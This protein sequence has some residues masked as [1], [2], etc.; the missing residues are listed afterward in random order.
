M[1][2]NDNFQ[3]FVTNIADALRIRYKTSGLFSPNEFYS[4]ILELSGVTD[5][6]SYEI[7]SVQQFTTH[8]GNS[9]RKARRLGN[10]LINPQDYYDHILKVSGDTVGDVCIYDMLNNNRLIVSVNDLS[11]YSDKSIYTP[12]GVVVIPSTHDIY[13]DGSCGIMALKEM[14]ATNTTEGITGHEYIHWG[15]PYTNTNLPYYQYVIGNDSSLNESGYLPNENGTYDSTPKS[16]SPYNSDGSRNELY[17]NTS[18]SS[19][20]ALSNFNGEFSTLVI[21]NMHYNED[22]NTI[23]NVTNSSDYAY[24]PAAACCYVYSP[25]NSGTERGDW[26]LPSCGELGYVYSKLNTINN[27]INKIIEVYGESYAVPLATDG[28]YLTSTEYN[29]QTCRSIYF[30]DG[31]VY[32][33]SKSGSGYIRPFLGEKGSLG[34]L[35]ININDVQVGDICIY[36]YAT[37]SKIFVNVDNLKYYADESRYT[38]VGVVVIPTSHN[39]YGD[40]SC[41]VMSLKEMNY[42]SNATQGTVT[43]TYMYFG[44]RNVDTSVPNYGNVITTNGTVVTASCLPNEDGEYTST[45][46]MSPSPYNSD[47]TRNEL[48]YDTTVSS[49]NA[50]SDFNGKENTKILADLHTANN[51]STTS[52][53]TNSNTSG[54]SPAA[55][56]C[57]VYSPIG[58]ETS[59]GDWYLPAC[60]ELGYVYTKM[61]TINNTLTVINELFGNAVSVLVGTNK[62]YWTSTETSNVR[63]MFVN[64][65]SGMVQYT[66]KYNGR[67]VRA[68]LKVTSDFVDLGLPSGNL[69]T[70][71]NIGASSP[72]ESGLYFAWG[73]TEGFTIDEFKN[74][75]RH[76]SWGDY[77][78]TSGACTGTTDDLFR[79][80][81]T[82][83]NNNPAN[84]TFD[85]LTTLELVDDAV[86]KLD[87]TMVIPS[88][89]DVNELMA[90]TTYTWEII[91]G[92]Q[93]GKFTSK[94]NGNS[95][96]MPASGFLVVGNHNNNGTYGT[97]WCSSINAG[98]TTHALNIGFDSNGVS[99]HDDGHRRCGLPLRGVKKV[100]K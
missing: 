61:K 32:K 11:N 60:G 28:E 51:L 41:A 89:E 33:L 29:Y 18:V 30:G 20:N 74:G 71:K 48:Y 73:E 57:Y 66:N 87:S 38:L 9:I 34:E 35:T 88:E 49:T 83:Y 8:I 5:T 3:D 80:G 45:T 19:G 70:T 22:I 15:Y 85:N 91:N 84:G 46:N 81:L 54:Y 76:F 63:A 31:G 64:M 75:K 39:V 86:N 36:D 14:T 50:L 79:G 10:V 98:S 96:I 99:L 21:S 59:R 56:C 82:K 52:V 90:N 17:Y 27:T 42:E 7:T 43:S 47:G 13:N 44:Q 94:I 93:C 25:T 100:N 62:S 4:K 16:P 68:F 23:T 26:Y 12:I 65:T 1:A 24:F 55:A 58:T 77:K 92:V 78:Y 69:W 97:F 67:Y 6:A 40:G 37:D 2:K 72:E 95:F 53:I